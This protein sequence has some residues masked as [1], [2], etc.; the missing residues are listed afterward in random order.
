M[1]TLYKRTSSGKVQIWY[2]E[3]H[4]DGNMYRTVSGQQDG[5]KVESTWKT[6]KGKNIGR[7]N[8]TNATEQCALVVESNYITQLAQ[9]NY[10]E[11]IEDIDN[12]RFFEPMLAGD[13]HTNK[14]ESGYSQPKMDGVRCILKKDGMWT[15]NGKPIVSCPHIIESMKDWFDKYPDDVFDGELYSDKLSDNFQKIISLARKTKDITSEEY[16]ESEQFLK[17][18]VYDYPGEAESVFGTRFMNF[19]NMYQKAF[20]DE[21]RKY[22]EIV[23]TIFLANKDEMDAEYASYMEAGFEGQMIRLDLGPYEHKRSKQ[24]L[25]RKEF[26]SEE[27]EVIDIIEGQGNWSEM[28][29]SVNIRLKD[30]QVQNCGMRGTQQFARDLLRNKKRYIGGEV[31][32]MYQRLSNDGKLIFP[33]GIAFF[34]GRRDV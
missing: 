8:E 23:D 24:L 3:I 4:P 16:A 14:P 9:G 17:L 32:V 30:G 27:F 26:L 15:R 20:T 7:A 29:K 28:A 1:K 19:C 31:T 2:Q 22:I 33:I 25:K 21:N 11:N 13:W 18:Y 12:T 5:K 6:V 10:W 34:D